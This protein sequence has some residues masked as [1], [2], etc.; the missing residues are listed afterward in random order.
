MKGL[1]NWADVLCICPASGKK[2]NEKFNCHS[3]WSQ[4][5]FCLVYIPNIWKHVLL[6]WFYIKLIYVKTQWASD[7]AFHKIIVGSIN[8]LLHTKICKN[9]DVPTF[10]LWKVVPCSTYTRKL[11]ICFFIFQFLI[12]IFSK[13]RRHKMWNKKINIK[14]HLCQQSKKKYV[15]LILLSEKSL[16]KLFIL[17]SN[18]R[19]HSPRFL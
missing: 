15:T 12:C 4:H 11:L 3:W 5:T 7:F 13:N 1:A 2:E 18:D 14:N 8:P 10:N 9:Y 6:Y 19:W 17:L 16:V